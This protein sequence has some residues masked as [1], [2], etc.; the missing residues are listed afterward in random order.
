M[1]K[2]DV[3]SW[4]GFGLV[5][6]A[7]VGAT[8]G[9]GILGFLKGGVVTGIGWAV[10]GLVAGALYGLWA[11]RSISARRLKGIGPI[12]SPGTSSLIAWADGAVREEALGEL[13]RPEAQ[14]LVLSFDP[15]PGGAVLE[16]R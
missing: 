15:V 4:G 2:S 5:F 6:G 13:A 16:A 12:L 11:G 3:V 8:G 14:R 9:G 1:S 7:I 10:F